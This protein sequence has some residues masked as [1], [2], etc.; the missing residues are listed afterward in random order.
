MTAPAVKPHSTGSGP[1]AIQDDFKNFIDLMAV[2]STAHHALAEMEAGINQQLLELVDDQRVEYAQIQMTLTESETALEEIA[3]SHPEWFA[4]KKSVK[5]PYGEVKFRASSK[6][7]IKNE[8]LTIV[9]IQRQIEAEESE[10]NPALGEIP[11]SGPLLRHSVALDLEAL[12]KLDD[13]ALKRF[14]IE[15]VANDNFSVAPAKVNLGKAVK[16]AAS[17]EAAPAQARRKEVA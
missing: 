15:R 5:T 1:S 13:A 10:V 7:A 8:E 2:Y 11:P 3:R 12:E 4:E 9:L 14:R 16:E 17:R 6:L